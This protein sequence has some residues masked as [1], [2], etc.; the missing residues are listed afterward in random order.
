MLFLSEFLR[1]HDYNIYYGYFILQY[2]QISTNVSV[3]LPI[4]RAI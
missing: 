1:T 4:G 3:L 2:T